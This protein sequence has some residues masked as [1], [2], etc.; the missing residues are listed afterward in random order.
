MRRV[1]RASCEEW[2]GMAK[3]KQSACKVSSLSVSLSSTVDGAR[4]SHSGKRT[5]V[6]IA[7]SR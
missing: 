2:Q 7:K 1:S 3:E 5:Q 4:V 6:R